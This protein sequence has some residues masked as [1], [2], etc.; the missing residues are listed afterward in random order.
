MKTHK[1]TIKLVRSFSLGFNIFSPK[2]NG[3]YVSINIACVSLCFWS[4]GKHLFGIQNFW[5]G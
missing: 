4:R 1:I 2:L 3:F 5:N